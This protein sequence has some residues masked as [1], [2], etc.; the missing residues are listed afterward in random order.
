[1]ASKRSYHKPSSKRSGRVTDR[2]RVSEERQHVDYAES[3]A[4]SRE[5]HASP[6]TSRTERTGRAVGRGLFRA[7]QAAKSGLSRAG[8]GLSRRWNQLSPAGKGL[9]IGLL[10]GVPVMFLWGR[11][12]GS[13][14]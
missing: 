9:V 6:S 2:Y 3:A 12:S 11:S 10:V 5:R 14:G 7:E 4:P 1:M 13:Q 8:G